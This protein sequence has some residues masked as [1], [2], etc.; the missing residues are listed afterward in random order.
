MLTEIKPQCVMKWLCACACARTCATHSQKAVLFLGGDTEKASEDKDV[1]QQ[2]VTFYWN[3]K[4]GSLR[5]KK[6]AG[7]LSESG[8]RSLVPHGDLLQVMDALLVNQ[9]HAEG[10]EVQDEALVQLEERKKRGKGWGGKRC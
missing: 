5:Y 10:G 6:K 1:C 2:R 8:V 9:T 4:K 7:V 3:I